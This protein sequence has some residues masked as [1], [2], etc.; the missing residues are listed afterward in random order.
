MGEVSPQTKQ[1]TNVEIHTVFS[2]NECYD[3]YVYILFK[4]WFTGNGRFE[5]CTRICFDVKLQ[6]NLYLGGCPVLWVI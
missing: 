3:Y 5:S 2:K 6:R 1:Q 4:F